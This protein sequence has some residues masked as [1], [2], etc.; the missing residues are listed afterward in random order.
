MKEADLLNEKVKEAAVKEKSV[1][2]AAIRVLTY[3][4]HHGEGTDQKVDLKRIAEVIRSTNPDIVA[5]QEVD[6]NMFRS[7]MEEQAAVL[8]KLTGMHHEFAKAIGFEGSEYGIAILSRLPMEWV[9]TTMLPNEQDGEPRVL[10]AAKLLPWQGLPSVVFANTHLEWQENIEL[11]AKIRTEQV[12]KIQKYL[13]DKT[14]YILAGD[15]N[16]LPDSLPMHILT[17]EAVDATASVGI[18]N[19]EDGKIDYILFDKKS[20]W[21]LVGSERI[22]D[23]TAS[24]HYPV[25]SILEWDPKVR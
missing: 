2:K 8:G 15:M 17:K 9:H 16:A 19:K 5:L 18:T 24:D 14:P 12:K 7:G 6:R 20:G 3:N 10:L 23:D 11:A 21:K 1:M 22:E 25:L 4:I 13:Q